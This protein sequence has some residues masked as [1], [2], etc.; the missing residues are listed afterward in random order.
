VDW[1]WSKKLKIYLTAAFGITG[2]LR[3]LRKPARCRW[4]IGAA[5]R[6]EK[7][8]VCALPP[9]LIDGWQLNRGYSRRLGSDARSGNDRDDPA[10]S[11]AGLNFH[12]GADQSSDERSLNGQ[13]CFQAAMLIIAAASRDFCICRLERLHALPR[14]GTRNG[15]ATTRYPDRAAA[16][17]AVGYRRV[18][19]RSN[20]TALSHKRR[21]RA[22]R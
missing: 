19:S 14:D 16:D 17:L 9:R 7:R 8:D 18:I 1:S 13:G 10:R 12:D 20:A 3:L 2:L 22:K 6:L 11:V 21:L 5:R 15:S 4:E